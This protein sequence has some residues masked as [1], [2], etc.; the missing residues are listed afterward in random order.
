VLA[1]SR[2]RR[3]YLTHEYDD[4]KRDAWQRL[5]VEIERVLASPVSSLRTNLA[6]SEAGSK[7]VVQPIVESR[8]DIRPRRTVSLTRQMN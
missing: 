2:V 6:R 5:G 3:H 8:P 1:G 4:E 7:K